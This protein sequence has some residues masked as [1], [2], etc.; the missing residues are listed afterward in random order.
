MKKKVKQRT[1][2]KVLEQESKNKNQIKT[3]GAKHKTESISWPTGLWQ[4]DCKQ[5]GKNITQLRSV[6]NF[7]I[8]K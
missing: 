4:F 1:T 3:T 8:L 2:E 6:K 5:T 7:H